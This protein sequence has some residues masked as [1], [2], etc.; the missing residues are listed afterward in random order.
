[1]SIVKGLSS[2]MSRKRY[3]DVQLAELLGCSVKEV[4]RYLSGESS[5]SIENL[6]LLL[7]DGLTLEEA[8]GEEISEAIKKNIDMS[9]NSD[10]DNAMSSMIDGLQQILDAAKRQKH[11]F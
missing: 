4:N 6:A 10:V 2:Y 8:F 1:M 9:S 7:K 11:K 5:L 3:K